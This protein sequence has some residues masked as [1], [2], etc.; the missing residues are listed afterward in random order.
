MSTAA[1][2][3]I[4]PAAQQ[5][6][7]NAAFEAMGRGPGTFFVALTNDPS[8]SPESTVTHYHMYDASAQ[9]EHFS[10]YAAAK[11]GT[12]LPP[13]AYGNPVAWGQDGIISQEDAFAAFA[14]LQQWANDSEED[15]VSFAAGRR[16]ALG[17]SVRPHPL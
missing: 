13:D 16:D 4:V 15:P 7:L 14:T 5:A 11:A 9:P 12:A 6:N 17:L 8:P 2:Y 3:A 10:E 1:I